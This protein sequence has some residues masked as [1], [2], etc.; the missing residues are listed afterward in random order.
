MEQEYVHLAYCVVCELAWGS[1]CTHQ[2]SSNHKKAPADTSG[3]QYEELL[4]SE[5][6]ILSKMINLSI[7]N[8]Y[9][10]RY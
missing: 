4:N 9:N 8:N 5:H 3:Q 10:N 1:I 2:A 6:R 7:L